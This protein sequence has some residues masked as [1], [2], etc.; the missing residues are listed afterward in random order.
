MG[1]LFFPDRRVREAFIQHFQSVV[2]SFLEH[3]SLV[4]CPTLCV[5]NFRQNVKCLGHV[6]ESMGNHTLVWIPVCTS[7]AGAM[8]VV[9]VGAVGPVSRGCRVPVCSHNSLPLLACWLGWGKG[10]PAQN[11]TP[12]FRSETL[13]QFILQ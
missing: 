6:R 3:F 1:L 10:L 5:F 2:K 8:F 13:I 7:D 12:T 11:E 9:Q 4:N